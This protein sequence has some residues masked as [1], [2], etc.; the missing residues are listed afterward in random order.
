MRILLFFF[1]IVLTSC[2]SDDASN[3]RFMKTIILIV[4]AGISILIKNYIQ[5]RQKNRT[6]EVQGA[7]EEPKQNNPQET[8]EFYKSENGYNEYFEAKSIYW[9]P[10]ATCVFGIIFLLYFSLVGYPL[11][12]FLLL[13]FWVGIG[14]YM[15]KEFKETHQVYRSL[16]LQPDRIILLLKNSEEP[17]EI[18]FHDIKSLRLEDIYE[19]GAHGIQSKTG[20]DL[21]LM[22][23][24]NKEIISFDYTQFKNSFR[25][26]TLLFKKM[27][28]ENL[29]K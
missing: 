13:I 7:N 3:S 10:I 12:G 1:P 29:T 9:R 28:V 22:D 2:S 17:I 23:V 16:N 25:L 11:V 5:S 18:N 14:M 6:Y 24:N 4:A 19:S 15:N 27:G 21:I 8:L 20:C 26:K